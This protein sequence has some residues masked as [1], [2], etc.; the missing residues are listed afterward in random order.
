MLS[1]ASTAR[2][3]STDFKNNCPVLDD[4]DGISLRSVGGIFIGAIT[5]LAL[6]MI[7]FLF[8]VCYIHFKFPLIGTKYH[9]PLVLEMGSVEEGEE[10]GMARINS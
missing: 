1:N 5:G 10:S 8:E 6:A 4:T 7:V 9:L 2:Y 3:W